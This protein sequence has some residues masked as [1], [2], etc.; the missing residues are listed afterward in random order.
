ME[1]IKK[2]SDL[3][4]G[5]SDITLSSVNENGYPRICVLSK[6]KS[7]GIK[8]VWC[9][10]GFTSQKV[11]HFKENPKASICFWKGGDSVTLL[12]K[13]TVRTDREIKEEMWIDWF[14]EHFPGGIDDPGYCILEF[15]TEETTLWIDNEFVTLSG[16]ALN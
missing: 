8:K 11:K 15:T 1:I 16:D 5:C 3:L 13:V 14:I 4:E 12:G 2:A 7:E 9:S 10:T 6:T